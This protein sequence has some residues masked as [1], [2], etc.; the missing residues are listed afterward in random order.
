MIWNHRTTPAAAPQTS[1]LCRHPP[2]GM[3]RRRQAGSSEQPKTIFAG[4]PHGLVEGPHLIKRNGWYYLTTAEGGTGYDHAVTMARSRR[5]DGPYELHPNVHL[6]TSKDAPDAALQRAGHGQIVETPDGQVYHTHLCSR[7]LAGPRGAR[8]SG[9][10][11]RSRNASGATTAG[12]IS[13]RAARFPPSRFRR[14]PRLEAEAEAAT[15]QSRTDF[16]PGRAAARFPVA[17]DAACRQDLLALGPPG[18]AAADRARIDRLL[19]RA[20]AR[21]APAGAFRLS[22]RNGARFPAVDAFSRRPASSAYYNRQKFHFL[23]VTWD[24]RL[25]RVLTILSCEGDFPEGA[26]EL[27]ARLA[28]PARRRRVRC[29]SPYRSTTRSFSSPTP[30]GGSGATPDPRSTPRS[31]RTK[32]EAANIARSPAPSSAWPLRRFGRRDQRRFPVFRVQG[33][34][35]AVGRPTARAPSQHMVGP[36]AAAMT[37]RRTVVG[38]CTIK[39]IYRKMG[40]C[41]KLAENQNL[42]YA[43][44]HDHNGSNLP[45]FRGAWRDGTTETV[46]SRTGPRKKILRS[47]PVTR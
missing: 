25:G 11:P 3:G 15:S 29:G 38:R 16:S 35:D 8:R 4:S 30:G 41:Q 23:A 21:R 19:V 2:A 42:D 32:P 47:T 44:P 6:L 7:P 5:I 17:A 22:R 46:Q 27:P 9:A 45:R 26:A 39:K 31:C 24:E 36:A 18:L 28:D 40:R 10:K 34:R 20:G 13:R 43:G 37:N 12:S 33:M 1:S 14:P